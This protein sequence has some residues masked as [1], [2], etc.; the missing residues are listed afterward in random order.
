MIKTDW[1]VRENSFSDNPWLLLTVILFA[2]TLIIVDIFIV[3]IA[4]ATLKGFYHTSDAYV[5]L[6]V[7]AYLIGFTIFMITGSRAGD[8]FGRKKVYCLGVIA[9]TLSSALCGWASTIGLLVLFRFFQ[10]AAAAFT[11]PQ[12]LTLMHLTFQGGKHRDKAYGI[13][14]IVTGLSAIG[15]QLLG[16]YF[17]SSHIIHDSWRL[18][19]LI[20][21]PVGIIAEVLAIVFLKESKEASARRFDLTGVLLLMLALTGIIIPVTRGRELGFPL[22]SLV[23]FV[24]AVL[25]FIVFIKNQVRKTNASH[26][27][28][29]N[30]N[31]FSVKKFNLGLLCVV[32][33]FGAHNAFLLNCTL[34]LQNGY[35]ISPTIASYLFLGFGAGFIVASAWSIKNA[36]R[37]GVLMLQSGS[38]LMIISL[39]LQSWL[40]GSH[41]PPLWHIVAC[42]LL[43]GFG[44]GLVLPSILNI[45]LKAV[46][47]HFAGTASGVYATVQQLS[48]AFGVSIISGFFLS[49]LQHGLHITRA[50]PLANVL[51]ITY[52]IL[53]IWFLRR[54]GKT[55]ENN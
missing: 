53:V 7:A 3:N 2:P 28:L 18:I 31:L 6:I 34:L 54:L 20:N 45:S 48:S 1:S 51:T 12:A 10:G 37:C 38:L 50:Y 33:F 47:A 9:F 26:P 24:L 25:L 27:V 42:L 44:N 40:F 29:I 46:P 36:A 30:T 41:T 35:G 55:T 23:L 11:M 43:Y 4:L 49:E 16:G 14:G 39:I 5:Q 15:G 19:F 21:I 8:R 17:I 13:Y 52:L 22:W 32:F